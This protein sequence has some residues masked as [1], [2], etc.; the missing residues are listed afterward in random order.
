MRRELSALLKKESP[1]VHSSFK[2]HLKGL[3][4]VRTVYRKESTLWPLDTVSR[5][6]LGVA[7]FDC[8]NVMDGN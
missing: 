6:L 8:N 4:L 3:R 1:K 2:R 7:N 5:V